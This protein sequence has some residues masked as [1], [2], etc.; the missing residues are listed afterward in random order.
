MKNILSVLL[1]AALFTACE[2]ESIRYMPQ[3]QLSV[4]F[5]EGSKKPLH[6][7]EMFDSVYYI[8][9]D[10]NYIVGHIDEVKPVGD[11]FYLINKRQGSIVKI[12]ER[13]EVLNTFTHKGHASGEYISMSDVFISHDGTIHVYDA[14]SHRINRYSEDGSYMSTITTEDF[15]MDF[16]VLCNGDYLFYTPS[17][18]HETCHRGLWKTDIEGN[19]KEQLVEID[20]DFKYHGGIIPTY[21]REIEPDT[22]GLLGSEDYDNIY[23]FTKDTIVASFSIDYG[24]KIPEYLHGERLPHYSENI[25]NVYAKYIYSE[26]KRWMSIGCTD[27][28]Q[29]LTFIYDKKN[30]ICYQITTQEDIVDDLYQVVSINEWE[31]GKSIFVLEASMIVEN[32]PLHNLFPHITEQSNPIISIGILSK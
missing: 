6:L 22:Y 1:F 15:P 21:I 30:D 25:G 3:K 11:C 8:T 2:D 13:G 24:I 27:F 16:V 31:S 23:A 14:P 5:G 12:N 10:S 7:S 29:S 28:E 18:D 32:E 26:S 19:F 17:F 4:R 20:N 9:I